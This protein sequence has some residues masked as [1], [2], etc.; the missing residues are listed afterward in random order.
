MAVLADVGGL[1]VCRRLADGVCSIV[2]ADA[3]VGDVHVVEIGR[4][5]CG[6]CVAVIAAVT[7]WYVHRVFA[8]RGYTVVTGSTAADNLTVVDSVCRR[9]DI[10]CMAVLTDVSALD[11]RWRLACRLCAIVTVK[12][13]ASDIYMVEI[14][15]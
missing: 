4:H 14:R 1:D 11:V 13:V 15:R 10:G 7:A 2:A 8:R 6:C 12:A 3:V 9:P 5:P